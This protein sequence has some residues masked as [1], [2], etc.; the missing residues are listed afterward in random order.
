MKPGPPVRNAARDAEIRR[1]YA[2]KEKTHRQLAAQHGV[3]RERI[4]QII[5]EGGEEGAA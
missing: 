3:S 5:R 4:G 1:C 2:A